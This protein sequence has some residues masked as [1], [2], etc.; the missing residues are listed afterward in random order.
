MSK[1]I[2][3][4]NDALRDQRHGEAVSHCLIALSPHRMNQNAHLFLNNNHPGFL[5][6]RCAIQ[7]VGIYQA[8]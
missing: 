6:V 3:T 8:K 4:Q 5:E 2:T 7:A 1:V